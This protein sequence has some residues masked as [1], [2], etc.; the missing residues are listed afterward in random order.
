MQNT[1]LDAGTDARVA[2]FS[3]K[4]LEILDLGFFEL[5]EIWD[6]SLS[7][8]TILES[9]HP[10][11]DSV[12]KSPHRPKHEKSPVPSVGGV[13]ASASNTSSSSLPERDASRTVNFAEPLPKEEKEVPKK[14]ARKVFGRLFRKKDPISSSTPLLLEVPN[15]PAALT[16]SFERV[17]IEQGAVP[18]SPPPTGGLVEPQLHHKSSTLLPPILDLQATLIRSSEHSRRPASYVWIVRRWLKKNRGEGLKAMLSAAGDKMSSL[19][20]PGLNMAQDDQLMEIEIRFDWER[21][22][23]RKTKRGRQPST[24]VKRGSVNNEEG[25]NIGRMPSMT[26]LKPRAGSRTRSSP[27]RE[28]VSVVSRDHAVES[29]REEESDPEDS[30]NPW[31]CTMTLRRL[32]PLTRP[33]SKFLNPSPTSSHIRPA[34]SSGRLENP[35][36]ERPLSMTSNLSAEPRDEN[37]PVRVKIASL[38]PAPHH[39]KIVAQLKVPYPLPDIDVHQGIVYR[40]KGKRSEKEAVRKE[41]AYMLSA[42]EIK[43]IICTTAFW[44]IVREGFGGV[45]KEKRKGDG[46]RIRG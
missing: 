7:V 6:S 33:S 19:N 39:P 2:K 27:D 29:D 15:T 23:K 45:G 9:S 32:Q 26:E 16:T 12:I 14:G 41:Q 40:R 38:H 42:E 28:S 5:F 8:N 36:L 25:G 13:S 31:T 11:K 37:T 20:F 4:G 46:W 44:M 17:S 18:L 21:N 1:V 30:E 43:D 22:D 10:K 34:T 3:K 24:R 35:R